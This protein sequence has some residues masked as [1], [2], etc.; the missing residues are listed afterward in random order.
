MMGRSRRLNRSDEGMAALGAMIS[1][2]VL[3][4]MLLVATTCAD[5][6]SS[7]QHAAGAADVSALAAAPDAVVAP[8]DACPRAEQIA[9]L[10][11][12]RIVSCQVEG[13]EVLVRVAVTPRTS[14]ARWVARLVA[15]SSDTVVAARARMDPTQG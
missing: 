2:V 12:A 3:S 9:S 8:D 10:N 13:D 4:C 7:R 14:W 11:G 1:V 5:L 15:S 6:L